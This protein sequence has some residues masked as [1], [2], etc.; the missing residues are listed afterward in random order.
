MG[1]SELEFVTPRKLQISA[2]PACTGHLRKGH[3][4]AEALAALRSEDEVKRRPRQ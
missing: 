4:A 3:E 1:C 2:K